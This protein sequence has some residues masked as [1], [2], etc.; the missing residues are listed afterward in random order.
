MTPDGFN[1]VSHAVETYKALFFSFLV[2]KIE[3]VQP[4]D[5][6]CFCNNFNFFYLE[7]LRR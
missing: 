7:L 3:N 4:D 2:T 6:L 1:Y 5:G